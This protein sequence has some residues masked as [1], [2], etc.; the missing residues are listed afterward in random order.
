MRK[1]FI[2]LDANGDG[3]L[4]LKELRKGLK[5]RHNGEQI[6]RILAAADTDG[7][8]E[9]N[10]T[11]FLAATIDANVYLREEYLRMAFKMFDTDNSGSIE[12]SEVVQILGGD[13]LNSL[14]TRTAIE[15][16]IDSIDKNGDGKVD[17][18]EFM[19]MMREASQNDLL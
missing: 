10:Y 19:A 6:A 13:Q 9:I 17:F 14:V 5:D 2:A 7:S 15:K 4:S 1:L 12:K 18:E 3:C 8:G 16:A 11:E